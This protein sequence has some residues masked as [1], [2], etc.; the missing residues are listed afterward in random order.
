[1]S[2]P[3]ID[4]PQPGPTTPLS[5]ALLKRLAWWLDAVA[6]PARSRILAL[7]EDAAAVGA[8]LGEPGNDAVNLVLGPAEPTMLEH[9]AHAPSS[10]DGVI[11]LGFVER[12]RWDRWG[13]QQIHRLLKPGGFLLL[14][15][16]NLYDP[17]SLMDPRYIASKLSKRLLRR[18]RSPDPGSR[19]GMG[20]AETRTYAARRLRDTLEDLDYDVERWSGV[21]GSPTSPLALLGRWIPTHHLV[22]ARRRP[23]DS[24]GRPDESPSREIVHRQ[25]FE[26]A[27]RDHL[28]RRE[29]WCRRHQVAREQPRALDLDGLVGARILVLA[30]HPD[31]EI[32]GC[33]GTLLRL[34]RAGARVTVLQATDGSASAALDQ[35]PLADRTTIRLEEARRVAEAAG[36]E[37][38]I[39]WREDN[40]AF[41]Y[42][43]ELVDR[44]RDTMERLAPAIVFTPFLTD[45]HGDHLTLNRILA[46]A[47]D[48]LPDTGLAILGYEVWSLVPANTWCDVSSCMDEVERLLW[49]YETAMK[50][51]DF[52]HMCLARNRHHALNLTGRPGFAEAFFATDPS[53]FRALVAG[54]STAGKTP[55]SGAVLPSSATPH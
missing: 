47:L 44:L 27:N 19:P 9:V 17:L 23:P 37:P 18:S 34:V 45:I 43:D 52:V 26:S 22:L 11:A 49:L 24:A 39:F 14:M 46:A 33:G 51:D 21:W 42:R 38:T 5:V 54:T 55:Q 4:R 53:R 41:Q 15:V 48:G 31:D 40:G 25:R 20:P 32:I 50:V 16:P 3:P 2:R 35:A 13:L 6:I 10:F 30:P 36:F 8:A 28:D 7:G 1:M 29:A 12:L